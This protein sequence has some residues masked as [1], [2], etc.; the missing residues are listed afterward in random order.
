MEYGVISDTVYMKLEFAN[1]RL[2][3]IRELIAN[4]QLSS[5]PNARHQ[6]TQEFFFHLTGSIEYLAQLLNECYKLGINC[7]DVAIYKVIK[8]IEYQN[9]TDATLKHIKSLSVN[10][11]RTPLPDD[12]YSDEGLI[13]RTINYR[14]EIVHRNTNPFHFKLSAGPK[15]SFFWLDPRNHSLGQSK[16]EVYFDLFNMYSLVYKKCHNTISILEK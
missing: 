4:N 2:K 16:Y 12:P 3:D 11:R 7:E 13:Y 5:N 6:L 10:T 15:I 14:N 8:K 1:N 9:S